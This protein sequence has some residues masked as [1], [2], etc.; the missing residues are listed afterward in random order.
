MGALD[1]TGQ[2]GWPLRCPMLAAVAPY[3]DGWLSMADQLD[4]RGQD[5]KRASFRDR[6]L[7]GADFSEADAR[8][9]NFSNAV[10]RDASFADVRLGVTPGTGTG[11]LV[12]S[13]VLSIGT[14]IAIGLLSVEI[15]ERVSSSDWRD[16]FAAY[17]LGV[18]VVAF[19]ALLIAKGSRVAFRIG[20]IVFLAV[21]VF[22]LLVVF[23]VADE[24]RLRQTM[25]LIVLFLLFV[26]AALA[27]VLGRVVGGE[28]GA[29]ALVLVAAT[30]GLAAGQSRGGIA[31]IVVMVILVIV[32]K[33]ALRADERDRN[34]QELA[35]RVITRFGTRFVGAD[36]SGADFRGTNVTHADMSNAVVDGVIW[37]EQAGPPPT[38]DAGSNQ[39]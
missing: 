19:L 23:F 17:T 30:G 28:F 26:P 2:P 18:V 4:F 7:A 25:P 1:A 35:H 21:F 38:P 16:T 36:I 13:L 37:D 20:L 34:L 33:R 22:D 27:G 39:P 32:S 14:G 6:D 10:L 12:A 29:W 24:L 11:I 3:L 5:L 15:F 8:G 9:A 31:A